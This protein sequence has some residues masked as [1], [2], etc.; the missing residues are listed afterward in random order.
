M[1]V[2]TTDDDG[3]YREHRG[4]PLLDIEES[5]AALDGFGSPLVRHD[6]LLWAT[7]QI[8]NHLADRRETPQTHTGHQRQQLPQ[9]PPYRRNR[10]R[11]QSLVGPAWWSRHAVA[12]I[13]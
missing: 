10:L 3:R 12:V 1:N 2:L 11:H 7:C 5:A 8:L 9:Q 4:H 13:A 6:E